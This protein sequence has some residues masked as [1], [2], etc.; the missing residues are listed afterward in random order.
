[1][2]EVVE[3]DGLVSQQRTITDKQNKIRLMYDIPK[4]RVFESL[5]VTASLVIGVRNHEYYREELLKDIYR[6]VYLNMIQMDK[7]KEYMDMLSSLIY[8][9]R[10]MKTYLA[11]I[12]GLVVQEKER[13]VNGIR[14]EFVPYTLL[15]VY[16]RDVGMTNIDLAILQVGIWLAPRVRQ[17]RHMIINKLLSTVRSSDSA[18]RSIQL[19]NAWI[20]KMT[21]KLQE[22]KKKITDIIQQVHYE[23]AINILLRT[24]AIL[25]AMLLYLHAWIEVGWLVYKN[26]NNLVFQRPEDEQREKDNYKNERLSEIAKG[27]TELRNIE[28]PLLEYAIYRLFSK[29]LEAGSNDKENDLLCPAAVELTYERNRASLDVRLFVQEHQLIERM[30]EILRVVTPNL[31]SSVQ[32]ISAEMDNVISAG[33][34]TS[35]YRPMRDEVLASCVLKSYYNGIYK[36]LDNLIKMLEKGLGTRDDWNM[37]QA[38]VTRNRKYLPMHYL[39]N[40]LLFAIVLESEVITYTAD[41]K[42]ERLDDMI[43]DMTEVEVMNLISNVMELINTVNSMKSQIAIKRGAVKTNVQFSTYDPKFPMISGNQPFIMYI[44]TVFTDHRDLLPQPLQLSIGSPAITG[45]SIR[46]ASG[47]RI[48]GHEI[49]AHILLAKSRVSDINLIEDKAKI[50]EIPGQIEND[51][52]VITE[53]SGY[54]VKRLKLKTLAGVSGKTKYGLDVIERINDGLMTTAYLRSKNVDKYIAELVNVTEEY[55]KLLYK[56]GRLAAT[57]SSGNECEIIDDKTI[58]CDV[59]ALGSILF[60]PIMARGDYEGVLL[61][62][63]GYLGQLWLALMVTKDLVETKTGGLI[64]VRDIMDSLK[65]VGKN[66]WRVMTVLYNN[67]KLVSVGFI[68]DRSTSYLDENNLFYRLV[69]NISATAIKNEK[70]NGIDQK[71]IILREDERITQDDMYKL[72]LHTDTS[73]MID[74]LRQLGQKIAQY[75]ISVSREVLGEITNIANMINTK[76]PKPLDFISMGTGLMTLYEQIYNTYNYKIILASDRVTTDSMTKEIFIRVLEI[77]DSFASLNGRVIKTIPRLINDL[78]HATRVISNTMVN[79][80]ERMLIMGDD[81]IH[82]SMHISQIV[83]YLD[84]VSISQLDRPLSYDPVPFTM[85]MW[86]EPL[87]MAISSEE[88]NSSRSMTKGIDPSTTQSNSGLGPGM[89]VGAARKNDTSVNI[90]NNVEAKNIAASTST[91]SAESKAKSEGSGNPLGEIGA[92]AA[93]GG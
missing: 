58:K 26:Q 43:I 79:G 69:E 78:F 23:R 35:V 18:A 8:T 46:Q 13:T 70:I 85:T 28:E 34:E 54:T 62:M 47:I 36:D 11:L 75:G 53:V 14:Y 45:Y 71:Y 59:R 10:S 49:Q 9:I 61:N 16:E 64:Q 7:D 33:I 72:I 83:N 41:V 1:M 65:P 93:L 63:N 92:A 21:E 60:E 15:K 66:K 17:L 67:G 90:V 84:N 50:I 51:S 3:I 88:V 27:M 29:P 86:K 39:L 38:L 73:Q 12:P 74:A 2:R 22:E 87:N 80:K 6:Q 20:S 55:H 57:Y 37:Y 32:A 68:E 89:E 25:T 82:N 24:E 44:P 52:I 91:S 40:S 77:T 19:L 5:D 81:I 42:V 76:L 4:R 30:K 31:V 56:I 48:P